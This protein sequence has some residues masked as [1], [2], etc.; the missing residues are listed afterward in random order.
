MRRVQNYV[1][2]RKDKPLRDA[3]SRLRIKAQ[4]HIIRCF[5]QYYRNDYIGEE[6]WSRTIERDRYV[7]VPSLHE[8]H[9][10]LAKEWDNNLRSQGFPE[11]FA[12]QKTPRA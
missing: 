8:Q 7:F 5:T 12:Q 3:G 10:R 4:L 1:E 6:H 9:E 2:Q 11:A